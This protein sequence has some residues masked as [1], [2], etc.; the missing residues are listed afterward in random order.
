LPLH[1]CVAHHPDEAGVTPELH[2]VEVC[3][4]ASHWAEG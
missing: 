4:A 3:V 1:V 2:I